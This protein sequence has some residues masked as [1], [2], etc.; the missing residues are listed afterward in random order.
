MNERRS[1]QYLILCNVPLVLNEKDHVEARQDSG[2]KV[3]VL[4][5]TYKQA[6]GPWRVSHDEQGCRQLSL[7][8]GV[9]QT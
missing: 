1:I 8:M 6:P 4:Y 3:N 7:P 2:L 5:R 9:L